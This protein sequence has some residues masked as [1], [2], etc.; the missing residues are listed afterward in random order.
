MANQSIVSTKV[1]VR[2][3]WEIYRALVTNQQL[4]NASGISQP[5]WQ[6]TLKRY[7]SWGDVSNIAYD[8]WWVSHQALFLAESPCVREIMT[9]DFTRRPHCLYLELPL[10]SRANDLIAEVRSCLRAK[11]IPLPGA[12]NKKQKKTV[13]GFTQGAEIRP[14]VYD[15]YILF[16]K[17]VYAP[18]CW[19][20]AITLRAIAK[21][22]FQGNMRKFPFLHL[23][24]VIDGK[25]IAYISMKRYRDKVK[26]LCKAVAGGEFPGKA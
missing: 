21:K 24:R 11:Q 3:W 12:K 6:D 2:F 9:T 23:D 1:K 4:R 20:R 7:Q 5:A 18:N 8:V 17:E 22:Q 25:P 14:K 10:N 16:L 19:G 26:Y 15:A 13:P